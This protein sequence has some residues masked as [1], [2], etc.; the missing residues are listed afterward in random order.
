MLDLSGKHEEVQINPQEVFKVELMKGKENKSK[1]GGLSITS[2]ISILT[3]AGVAYGF[4]YNAVNYTA[5]NRPYVDIRPYAF[6]LVENKNSST[7]FHGL[8]R[9]EIMNYGDVPAYNFRVKNI[10]CT[11][12]GSENGGVFTD[13]DI[14]G[15]LNF[16]R[17]D[18]LSPKKMF[19]VEK[20]F[21]FELSKDTYSK[22]QDGKESFII[23]IK[24]NY[25]GPT[26]RLLFWKKS[27]YWYS[28][29]SE[30][31]KGVFIH[32]PKGN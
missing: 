21:S 4:I 5:I 30:Y 23:E 3:L 15:L 25:E 7:D 14:P 18:W 17:R 10:K 19:R 11:R 16:F 12:H 9:F 20:G 24:T 32:S 2:T 13:K 29:K 6:E 1:K 8:L 26:R 31:M 22:Y 28:I 27:D